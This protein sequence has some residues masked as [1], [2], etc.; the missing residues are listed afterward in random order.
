ME[1]LDLATAICEGCGAV[2]T[3]CRLGD[4]GWFFDL[5]LTPEGPYEIVR[6]P[7]CW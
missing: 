4:E 7:E 2:S 1:T 6:C 5:V 3:T